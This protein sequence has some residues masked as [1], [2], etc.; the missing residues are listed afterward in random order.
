MK[1]QNLVT[2]TALSAGVLLGLL[3]MFLSS[4]CAQ[5][6]A[7]QPIYITVEAPEP[8]PPAEPEPAPVAAEPAVEDVEDAHSPEEKRLIAIFRAKLSDTYLLWS[9]DQQEQGND[10]Y[11]QALDA[12]IL[13]KD[14]H[15]W[16]DEEIE[17]LSLD[18][19]L[20]L[21]LSYKDDVKA[22]ERINRYTFAFIEGLDED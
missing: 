2:R 12:I 22:L 18:I 5:E 9:L 20:E 1:G 11:I 3:L 21:L 15:G 4:G 6:D 17:K 13:L 7:P 16:T 14:N 10:S 8:E 19:A